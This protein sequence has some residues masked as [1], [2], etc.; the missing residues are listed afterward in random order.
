MENL[1]HGDFI[2]VHDY[3]FSDRSEHMVMLKKFVLEA[4]WH[5]IVK[6]LHEDPYALVMRLKNIKQDNSMFIRN[7]VLQI[8]DRQYYRAMVVSSANQ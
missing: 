4:S 8:R 5:R 2:F 7:S 1:R 6:L 3:T